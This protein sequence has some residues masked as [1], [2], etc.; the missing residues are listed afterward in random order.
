MDNLLNLLQLFSKNNNQS[1][2]HEEHPIPKE[3]LDQYPYGDF[4]IKYTKMGQEHLRKASENRY[5]HVDPN[6]NNECHENNNLDISQ[7]L[8]LIQI[9]TNKKSSED[10]FKAFSKILFKNNKELLGLLNLFGNSK[11]QSQE[12]ETTQ[13]FPETNKV[14]I[15]SLRR[16]E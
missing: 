13:P 6:P 3:I 15:S 2:T 11:I 16:I 10:I 4:P 7:L 1:K 5:S 14:N 12:L 8:P 9:L